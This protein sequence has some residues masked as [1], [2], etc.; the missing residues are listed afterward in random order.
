[1]EALHTISLGNNRYIWFSTTSKWN[2]EKDEKFIAWLG[3]SN[4]D[5]LPGVPRG[6]QARYLVEYKNNLTGKYFKWISQLAVFSLHGVGCDPI[7]FDLWKASGELSALVWCTKI[8][9]MDQYVVR[10][11]QIYSEAT[12][13]PPQADLDVAVANVLDIWAK[14]DPN[15]IIVKQK[16]HVLTHLRDDVRRF[17]P[18]SLYEVEA[19]ESSNKVFRQCSI[20]SNHHAPSRDIATTMARLE[21]F[22]HIISGGWWWD[23]VAK[24]YV[25]AGKHITRDFDSKR[26]LQSH[27]GWTPDRQRSPGNHIGRYESTLTHSPPV[28]GSITHV[29]NDK[30]PRDCAWDSLFSGLPP[31][32]PSGVGG[33][34]RFRLGETIISR[35]GDV[36]SEGSWVFYNTHNVCSTIL[37]VIRTRSLIVSGRVPFERCAHLQDC[38]KQ[39]R[40][41]DIIHCSRGM[42]SIRTE[43]QSLRDARSPS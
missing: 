1:M 16:L 23:E 30:Q 12:V 28:L 4:V 32:R 31:V 6:V 19:F 14:V 40:H 43:R 9:D 42:E 5:G 8:L 35:S 34:T 24:R 37:S 10:I 38:Y 17:G 7:L 41:G 11:D 21:R 29:P 27:L 20:L 15:R 13:T 3:A 25:Q 2:E 22:K 18:P 26:F 39:R 36:C 33:E